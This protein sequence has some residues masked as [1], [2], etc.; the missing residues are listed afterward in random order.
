MKIT[1][2]KKIIL[3]L[4][5]LA[6]YSLI[7]YFIFEK[8]GCL[9]FNIFGIPC[10]SC[11]MTR[12]WLCFFFG[13]IKKAFYYHPL[14]FFAAIIPIAAIFERA[15]LRLP[16]AVY[17]FMAMALVVVWV[18]RM[19]LYFPNGEVMVINKSALI[20]WVLNKIRITK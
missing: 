7:S 6:A 20:F 19:V 4:I 3:F 13:E 9:L 16:T 8:G 18:A 14:F 5:C 12:A 2:D 15:R 1:N 10:P 17:I 11:G